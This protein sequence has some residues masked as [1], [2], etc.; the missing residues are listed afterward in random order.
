MLDKIT[1]VNMERENEAGQRSDGTW[2]CKNLKFRD[3]N[4]LRDK[5]ILINEVL[6]EMNSNNKYKFKHPKEAKK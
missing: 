5:I 1:Y 2:Y 4:D 3:N 6:N